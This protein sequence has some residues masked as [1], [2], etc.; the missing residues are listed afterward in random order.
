MSDH[1]NYALIAGVFTP[2]AHIFQDV[3]VCECDECCAEIDGDY[4]CVCKE[5]DQNQCDIH[6]PAVDA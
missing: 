5:C 1:G 6:P 4:Y 2:I 3:C